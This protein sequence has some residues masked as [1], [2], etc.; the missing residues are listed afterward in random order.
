[1][2][3]KIFGQ[4]KRRTPQ[5]VIADLGVHHVEGFILAAGFTAERFQFDYGY[6]CLMVTYDEDGYIEP[7][8]IRIQVKAKESLTPVGGASGFELDVRDVNLWLLERSLVILVLY[9]A[10]NKRAHWLDVQQWFREQPS[11]LPVK[12]AKT[13]RVRIPTSQ[14]WN[15]R[16]VQH[17][18]Q[19]KMIPYLKLKEPSNGAAN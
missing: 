18:R 2:P 6:D 7:C 9:D 4:R 11:R 13:I 16:T 10:S 3:S 12:G 1:M 5:H 17:L 15:R 8:A 14:R 19:R